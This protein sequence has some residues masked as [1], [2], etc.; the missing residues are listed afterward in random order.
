MFGR[1][2]RIVGMASWVVRFRIAEPLFLVTEF[3]GD[4]AEIAKQLR[5]LGETILGEQVAQKTAADLIDDLP[6]IN[7][8]L[9]TRYVDAVEK[10]KVKVGDRNE[11]HTPWGISIERADFIPFDIGKDVAEAL[12]GIVTAKADARSTQITADATKYKLG[13]EGRGEGIKAENIIAGEGRGIQRK[14]KS[15]GLEP[16]EV[17]AAEVAKETVGESDIILGTEGVAQALALGKT[18]FGNKKPAGNGGTN[19]ADDQQSN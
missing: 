9:H 10:G 18:I 12:Q 6:S 7:A 4:I 15:L 1:A 19:P 11:V 17:L 2:N 14:A 5:D 16:S 3:A 8:D 13:Q